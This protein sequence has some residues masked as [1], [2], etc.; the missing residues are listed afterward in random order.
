MGHNSIER[1]DDDAVGHK[2]SIPQKVVEEWL[3]MM[4]VN[5]WVIII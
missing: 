5:L 3:M 4:M 2:E 1:D